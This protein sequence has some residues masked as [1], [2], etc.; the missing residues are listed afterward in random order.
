MQGSGLS[1]AMGVE[2]DSETVRRLRVSRNESQ[3][4]D[5]AAATHV[6]DLQSRHVADTYRPQTEHQIAFALLKG[7]EIRRIERRV[8]TV[9]SINLANG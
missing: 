4:L 7:Q 1:Y 3:Q 5:P 2:I 6:E 8:A 9:G